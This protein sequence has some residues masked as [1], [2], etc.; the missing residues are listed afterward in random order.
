M[1]SSLSEAKA[2]V[3]SK[4]ATYGI[5]MLIILFTSRWFGLILLPFIKFSADGAIASVI[6]IRRQLGQQV[7]DTMAKAQAI[8]MVCTRLV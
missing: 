7:Q 5:M 4:S 8:D 6:W 2:S 1:R 3:T